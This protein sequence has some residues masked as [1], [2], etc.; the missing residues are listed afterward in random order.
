LT[1]APPLFPLGSEP[2]SL[3][4]RLNGILQRLYAGEP[5]SCGRVVKAAKLAGQRRDAL[6]VTVCLPGPASEHGLGEH[7]RGA[8]TTVVRKPTDN[9][10]IPVTGKRHRP[11]LLRSDAYDACADQFRLLTPYP[12]R[13]CVHPRSTDRRTVARP[14]DDSSIPVNGNRDRI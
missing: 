3:A 9:G 1:R 4:K 11:A 5:Q 14:T 2:L 6:A 8:D 12:A 7:P 13:A 10:S